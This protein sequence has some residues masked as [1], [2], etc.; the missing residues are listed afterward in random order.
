M[1]YTLLVW[2]QRHTSATNTA[3]ILAGEPIF[4][5]VTSYIVLH[6]RLGG[7]AIVGAALILAGI[8][9]AELKGAIPQPVAG[10]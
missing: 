5:A 3:L 2:G 9:V 10:A 6:E 4:A 8:L 1:A 7:R